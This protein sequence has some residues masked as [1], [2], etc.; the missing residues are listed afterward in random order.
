MGWIGEGVL[1][2]GK[3][4][5]SQWCQA[6]VKKAKVKICCGNGRFVGDTWGDLSL[7]HG[8]SRNL[9]GALSSW[10]QHSIKDKMEAAQRKTTVV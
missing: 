3:L 9:N 4:S 1:V 6:V 5:M 2:G 8:I 7:S 10:S